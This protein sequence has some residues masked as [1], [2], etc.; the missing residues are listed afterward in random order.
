MGT[1]AT[2]ARSTIPGSAR[3]APGPRGHLLFGS[4]AHYFRDP[5]TFLTLLARDYGDVVRFRLG[6]VRCCLISH[7]D[8]IEEVLRIKQH[9]FIKNKL[10]QLSRPIFGRGLLTSDGDLWRRQRRLVQP[11]FL[12]QKVQGYGEIMMSSTARMLR[13]WQTVEVR[14][15]CEDLANLALDIVARIFF[16]ADLTG[17]QD[18]VGEIVTVLSDHF[19]KPFH[20]SLVGRWLPTRANRRLLRAI[21]RLDEIMEGMIGQA[22]EGRGD[23]DGLLPRLRVAQREDGCRMDDKQFRDEAVTILLGGI[24]TPALGMAYALYL[25]AQHPEAAARLATEVDEALEGRTP[26]ADDIPRLRYA[27]WVIKEAMRIYPPVWAIGREALSDCEVGGYRIKRGTQVLMNQWVVHHDARWFSD[28][29]AF[30][31]ER[32]DNDFERRL[33]RGAY[34]PFGDGPR[35]CIGIH[36]AMLEMVLILAA[37]AQRFHLS[38]APGQTLELVPALSLRPKHG[39][40]MIIRE[41]AE[42]RYRSGT[43]ID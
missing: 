19:L 16:D 1:Q 32:W 3:V 42:S 4:I 5:L 12:Q 33:P 14:D 24:D 26:T 23:P 43:S 25:L 9:H 13:S 37:I 35:S 8:Q 27:E 20:F 31:P 29:G 38:L 10:L 17:Q 15:V 30:R 7:P 2:S 18:E 36:F 22:G 28:P 11:P 21:R 6:T 34:F 41:R 40:K 39:I